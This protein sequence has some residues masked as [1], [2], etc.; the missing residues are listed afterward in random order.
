MRKAFTLIELLVV[1]GLIALLMS[2]VMPVGKK[3]VDNIEKRIERSK[4]RRE[5]DESLFEAFLKDEANLD[6]NISFYGIAF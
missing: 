5:F 6:K 1:M 3:F 2:V 4:E